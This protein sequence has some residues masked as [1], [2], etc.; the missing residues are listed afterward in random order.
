MLH[1]SFDRSPFPHGRIVSLRATATSILLGTARDLEVDGIGP[2]QTGRINGFHH[3]DDPRWPDTFPYPL[4]Q[5]RVCYIGEPIAI[6]PT[7]TEA[8]AR[9][10][11][12]A[13]EVEHA[14][15]P[16]TA[17]LAVAAAQPLLVPLHGAWLG[18][19]LPIIPRGDTTATIS[20]FAAAADLL[21]I[22]VPISRIAGAALEPRGALALVAGDVTRVIGTGTPRHWQVRDTLAAT[23][24]ILPGQLHLGFKDVGGAPAGRVPGGGVGAAE[25][26]ARSEAPG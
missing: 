15:D 6:I 4:A 2:N 23:L 16:G 13:I 24:G 9:D 1:T 22:G 17:D 7:T 20:A 5:G 11:T 26:G 10:A 3:L 18:G 19:I 8:A 21:T 25:P 14:T 12:E